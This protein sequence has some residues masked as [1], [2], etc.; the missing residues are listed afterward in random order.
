MPRNPPLEERFWAKVNKDGPIPE[1]RPELGP[2]WVWTGS[3][4][5]GYPILTRDGRDVRGH[6]LSCQRPTLAQ[7]ETANSLRAIL[8]DLSEDGVVGA[9][10]GDQEFFLRPDGTLESGL[11]F[12]APG[13]YDSLPHKVVRDTEPGDGQLVE[14]LRK[15]IVALWHKTPPG[16]T[17][18]LHDCLGMT[19]AEYQAWATGQRPVVRDTEREHE[20][21]K[22]NVPGRRV[23]EDDGT[24]G[25]MVVASAYSREQGVIDAL[26]ILQNRTIGSPEAC[27]RAIDRLV[28]GLAAAEPDH[29]EVLA[30]ALDQFFLAPRNGGDDFT[31]RRT[32]WD[33]VKPTLQALGYPKEAGT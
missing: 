15:S 3:L 33:A 14:R 31:A 9:T 5:R 2:C 27:E 26:R 22:V 24:E 29:A 18:E 12:L 8:G 7:V 21:A 30:K 17:P 16:S 19:W 23:I 6:R 28:A 11:S 1:H 13:E 20:P 10:R 4:S 32:L 25:N